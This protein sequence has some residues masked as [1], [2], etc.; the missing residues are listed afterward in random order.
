MGMKMIVMIRMTDR[1]TAIVTSTETNPTPAQ[2]SA[3]ARIALTTLGS[4][5]ENSASSAQPNRNDAEKKSIRRKTLV[6]EIPDPP[7]TPIG[8]LGGLSPFTWIFSS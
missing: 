4:Q 1:H 3:S 6:L 8:P 5:A 7:T 2:R